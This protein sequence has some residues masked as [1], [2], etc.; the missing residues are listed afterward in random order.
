MMEIRIVFDVLKFAFE[1]QPACVSLIFFI[2]TGVNFEPQ[3]AYLI[4]SSKKRVGEN[5][6]KLRD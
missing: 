3:F 5:L 6:C 1:V 4:V 2:F